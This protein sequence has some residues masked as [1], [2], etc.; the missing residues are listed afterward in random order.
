MLLPDFI[1]W[2]LKFFFFFF[3]RSVVRVT[4]AMQIKAAIEAIFVAMVRGFSSFA[5]DVAGFCEDW[6]L[7]S[8]QSLG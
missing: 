8:L 6:G 3:V 7:D 4:V 2:L 5:C 1:K